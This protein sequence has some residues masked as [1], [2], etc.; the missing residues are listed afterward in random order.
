MSVS[1]PTAIFRLLDFELLSRSFDRPLAS[2]SEIKAWPPPNQKLRLPEHDRAPSTPATTQ[3][4]LTENIV[5]E[6]VL[7]LWRRSSAG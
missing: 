3:D 7:G 5:D 4:T 6:N 2:T 1:S